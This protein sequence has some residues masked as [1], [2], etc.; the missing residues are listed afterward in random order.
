[1]DEYFAAVKQLPGFLANVF[2]Q[3]PQQ[4][5]LAVQEVRLRAF[6]PPGL[7][8]HG[9]FLSAA[10]YD[11]ALAP[12]RGLLLTEQQ[13]EEILLHLCGHSLHSYEEQL[14]HGYITLSGGQRVGVA[15]SYVTAQNVGYSL[16]QPTSL[17]LRIA[18][19]RIVDLPPP[20]LEFL[21]QNSFGGILLVGEPGSGK[22]TALRSI[23]QFL[24]RQG[25]CCAVL[26]EREEIMS[27][28]VRRYLHGL[29]V[30][31][32]IPKAAAAQMA[33]RTLAPQVM[34]LDELGELNEVTALQQGLAAGVDF[35]ATMHAG[36]LQQA[37]QRPQFRLL[38][39]NGMVQC[40]CR[41]SGRNA[42]G[43]FAEV[44]LL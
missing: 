43:S 14:S 36:S 23:A 32:G 27:K 9:C 20:L 15:G 22:T 12:L 28:E 24:C 3:L 6:Q 31:S 37:Q 1:M 8:V 18:R 34:L 13:I 4:K 30:I 2:V 7:T 44:K 38:R 19:D 25:R 33:L 40:L 41:M 29:D 11:T 42:P 16:V 17:N 21:G 10:Q 5:A 26:D 39:Q 35:I